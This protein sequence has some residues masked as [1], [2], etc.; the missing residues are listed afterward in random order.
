MKCFKLFLFISLIQD[1]H[2]GLCSALAT[3]KKGQPQLYD[4][5]THHQQQQNSKAK[6]LNR[7]SFLR[8][9]F[10]SF[11]GTALA[12]A[13]FPVRVDALKERNEALCSTGFFTNIA[14]WYCTDIGDISDEGVGRSLSQVEE[15]AAD[16]LLNKIDFDNDATM[17]K[18][19]IATN[20]SDNSDEAF[21]RSSKDI[22]KL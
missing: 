1:L 5:T 10:T 4:V 16:S 15:N 3:R 11:V 7:Q 13:S 19:Q 21:S 12:A 18:E 6:Q 22:P 14:Q 20:N 9:S 2:I 17:D 8:K